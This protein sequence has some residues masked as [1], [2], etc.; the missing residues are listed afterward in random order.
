MTRNHDCP[1]TGTCAI[2]AGQNPATWMLEV[3]GG[4]MAMVSQP[5]SIDWPAIYAASSLAASNA[6][7]CERLVQEGLA[8]GMQLKMTSMYAQP[9]NIQVM[10]VVQPLAVTSSYLNRE[11]LNGAQSEPGWPGGG[12]AVV[13]AMH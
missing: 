1:R 5:N 10:T 9:F 4:S 11:N 2:A 6:M 12:T 8:S 3:T 7:E 13:W